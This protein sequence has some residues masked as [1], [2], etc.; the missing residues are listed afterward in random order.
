[1]MP[2]RL[3]APALL[4]VAPCA[5]ALVAAHPL[6]A[7]LCPLLLTPRGAAQKY[8]THI[9]QV[10]ADDGGAGGAE[11]QL[12][13]FVLKYDAAEAEAGEGEDEDAAERWQQSLLE[14]M[15]RRECVRRPPHGVRSYPV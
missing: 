11:E 1:M 8:H 13:W 3:L 7:A 12:M 4:R 6:R 9:A 14:R 10:L 5:P 2:L 15:E